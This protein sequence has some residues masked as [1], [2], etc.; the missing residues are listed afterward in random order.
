M[1][2]H[3]LIELAQQTPRHPALVL[4][5]VPVGYAQLARHILG[6][7]ALWAP[8]ELPAGTIAVILTAGP[9]HN[10]VA[11]LALRSLGLSTVC[12]PTLERIDQLGLGRVACVVVRTGVDTTGLPWPQAVVLEHQRKLPLADLPGPGEP[13]AAW[14][15]GAH[16]LLSSGTTGRPKKLLFDGALDAERSAESARLFGAGPGTVLHIADLGL[17]TGAGYKWPLWTWQAGGTVVVDQR[18]DWPRHFHAQAPTIAALTPALAA[19]LLAG[20]VDAADT[21][22]APVTLYLGGARPAAELVQALRRRVPG[23]LIHFFGAT[24]LLPYAM[25][26]EVEN[27]SDLDW[28]QVQ[29][30]REAQVVREDGQPCAAGEPGQLRVRLGPLDSHAYLDDPETSARVFR[31][32]YFHPGDLA[33]RRADGRIRVLGRATDVVNIAGRKLPSAPLEDRVRRAFGV[34]E[35][36]AFSGPDASGDNALF[37]VIETPRPLSVQ[38]LQQGLDELSPGHV[39]IVQLA[40]LPRTANGT[41]KI[42]RLALRR[43]VLSTLEAPSAGA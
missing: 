2:L 30:G 41:G 35:V 25:A 38:G 5:G 36:C 10:W 37:V 24:E 42:D 6:L 12:V 21:A 43:Q 20:L 14:P 1:I 34:A 27:P 22:P 16:I 15:P 23:R 32:G 18:P 39:H 4:S 11:S 9:L 31:D 17:W 40:R 33:E 28:L 7:R 8:L 26:C 19:T 29:E 13:C 3:R